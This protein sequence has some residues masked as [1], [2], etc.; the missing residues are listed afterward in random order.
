MLVA[1][2]SIQKCPKRNNYVSDMHRGSDIK[3]SHS[4]KNESRYHTSS[5]RERELE[6]KRREWMIEQDR[7]REHERRKQKMIREYEEKRARELGLKSRSERSSNGSTSRS[8]SH[9]PR[10]SCT[11]STK[12]DTRSMKSIVMSEKLDASSS[13]VR[14]FKGPEGTKIPV[15]DLKKIKVDIRRNIDAPEK[16]NELQRNI[17]DPEAVVL[18]RREGEGAKPIFEREELRKSEK[19]NEREVEER[20]TVVAIGAAT[21]SRRRSVSLSPERRR[22][23]RSPR[24]DSRYETSSRNHA[25]KVNYNPNSD[26]RRDRSRESR[27]RHRMRNHRSPDQTSQDHSRGY[28][29]RRSHSDERSNRHKSRRDSSICEHERH[30]VRSRRYEDSRLSNRR[31]ELPPHHYLEPVPVPF[32]YGNFARPIMVDP[33]MAMRGPIGIRGRMPPMMG[34]VRPPYPPRFIPPTMFR[35]QGPANARF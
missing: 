2:E 12:T 3:M 8:R 15:S 26:Y 17:L 25:D 30:E 31:M 35:P 14:L 20:R 27:D 16:T 6:R 33:M 29:R 24:R 10:K 9:S 23:N 18:K 28:R 32:Y 19:I 5:S 22:R 1:N 4:D 13:N 7:A 21:S 11:K 34:P